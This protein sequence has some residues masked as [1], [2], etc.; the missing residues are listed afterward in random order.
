MRTRSASHCLFVIAI[1][2]CPL[3]A[4]AEPEPEYVRA[5]WWPSEWGKDDQLGAMN[6]LTPAKVLEAAQLIEQG[7][8]YDMGRV[9]EEDMPLFD[10]TPG[11]RKYTLSIPGAPTWGPLGENRLAWNEEY[12]SGHLAQDGTQFDSLAH[13]GTVRGEPGDLNAIHYYNGWTHAE[14]AGSRGFSRLGVENTVPVFTRGILIDIAGHKGRMLERSEEI[15]VADLRAALQ[16]QGLSEADIR[17]GD[18]LFYHTGWASLWKTDNAKFNSGTPGLSIEAGDWVVERKVVLVGTDNWAVEAI[19]N[20]D[21]NWFAPNHQK[22]LVENGIY[23]MENLDF[24]RLIAAGVY[25]FA[26]VFSAIP[27]KG[28]TGSPARPFAIR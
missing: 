12:I 27:L 18:A 20:P 13:M 4:F 26:F 25:E 1:L 9:F 17:P 8:V 11:A 3:I 19:P 24:S 2:C 23:I 16:R 7:V 6:R 21:P 28:A 14:I 10:L 15:S 22:F 5:T